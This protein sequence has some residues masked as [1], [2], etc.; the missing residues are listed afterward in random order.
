LFDITNDGKSK[1]GGGEV[2][3]CM[4]NARE[5]NILKESI[6]ELRKKY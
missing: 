6:I 5:A 3:L 4:Y 1:I 2:R